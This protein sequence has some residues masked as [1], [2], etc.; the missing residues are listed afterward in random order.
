MLLPTKHENLEK[1]LLVLGSDIIFILKKEKQNIENLFQKI[2]NKKSV[3]IDQFYNALTFLWLAE[4]IEQ[5][6]FNLKLKK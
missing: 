5:D 2:K 3:N 1:N 6:D 4:I